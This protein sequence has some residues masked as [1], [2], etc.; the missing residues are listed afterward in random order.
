MLVEKLREDEIQKILADEIGRRVYAAGLSPAQIN[1]YVLSEDESVQTG[2]EGLTCEATLERINCTNSM[3]D[4]AQ[5]QTINSHSERAGVRTRAAA[6]SMYRLL[7]S[8]NQLLGVFDH[9]QA[10][11]LRQEIKTLLREIDNDQAWPQPSV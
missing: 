11:A 10:Q 3:G 8:A 9:P 1:F 2:I 7:V 6:P 4:S 5:Q